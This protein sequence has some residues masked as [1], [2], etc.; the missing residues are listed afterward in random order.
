MKAT[1][2]AHDKQV[3]LNT[4]KNYNALQAMKPWA[5]PE[6]VAAFAKG[7]GNPRG[8]GGFPP[9]GGGRPGNA[10][11][12]RNDGFFPGGH[13]FQNP[14]LKG[15]PGRGQYNSPPKFQRNNA[16]Q[17]QQRHNANSGNPG[18]NNSGANNN[19][20]NNSYNQKSRPQGKAFRGGGH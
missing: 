9:R 13:Q 14:Q 8:R 12:P 18:Q 4:N 17:G 6:D 1:S 3:S 10:F 11:S 2:K 19:N 20:F 16:P 15:N 5:S 7:R